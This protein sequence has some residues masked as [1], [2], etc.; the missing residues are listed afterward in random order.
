MGCNPWSW[1]KDLTLG[2]KPATDPA[3]PCY[4]RQVIGLTPH[5]RIRLLFVPHRI[6]FLLATV[7]LVALFGAARLDYQ[8]NP[9]DMYLR[10][11]PETDLLEHIYQTFGSDD[12]TVF[13]LF[14][15][16][17][18][19]FSPKPL[20]QLQATAE[21]LER[22]PGVESVRSLFD[23][24]RQS[25]PVPL[26]DL[27]D[28]NQSYLDAVESAAKRHPLAS[29]LLLSQQGDATTLTVRLAG[30]SL[31]IQEMTGVL[32]QIQKAVAP[33]KQSDLWQVH[34]TGPTVIR[35]ESMQRLWAEQ[36]KLAL[37]GGT[38]S[39]LIAC[40]LFRQW[41]AILVVLLGP[42]LGVLWTLGL[43][44]W[45]GQR[46]D[47]IKVIIPTLV[48]VIGFTDSLHLLMGL[49]RIQRAAGYRLSTFAAAR[50]VVGELGLACWMTS[51]TTAIGFGSL[52]L[53]STTSVQRFGFCC[54]L[55]AIVLYGAVMLSFFWLASQALGS[56]IVKARPFQRRMPQR[57]WLLGKVVRLLRY[58]KT[59]VVTSV[60]G[61]GAMLVVCTRLEPNIIWTEAV[62]RTSPTMQAIAST[63]KHF[64]GT[65]Y[66]AILVR[67]NETQTLTSPE[68]VRAMAAAH[69]LVKLQPEF[70]PPLS[71]ANVLASMD[72]VRG[73]YARRWQSLQRQPTGQQTASQFVC[74]DQREAVIYFLTADLGARRINEVVRAV[75]EQLTQVQQQT[76]VE[77]IL[78][79]TPV[80]AGRVFTSMI[81]ELAL[82]L[83]V[84]S[85]LVFALM[86]FVLRSLRLGVAS[87]LP[88]MFPLLVAG[89]AIY[90]TT[91]FLTLTNT[92]TFC[93]CLGI[94][95]DDTIHYLKAF[96]LCRRQGMPVPRSIVVSLHRVG[97]VLLVSSMILI[98]GMVAMLFS[99]LPPLQTFSALAILAIVAALIGD[100]LL[101]PAILLLLT[102]KTHRPGQGVQVAPPAQF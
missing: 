37:I 38:L 51:L 91:G 52:M 27:R 58:P 45:L 9:R 55:G 61:C 8:D 41:Q 99:D 4:H 10:A 69:Q 60:M 11:G 29:G 6:G 59:I 54:A 101:L 63:E 1:W 20:R 22:I 17:Q 64:G 100:L 72:Y 73:G 93:L 19:L 44:G 92:L 35:V 62:S 82:S 7:S 70:G 26:I 18:R 80:V 88:N 53:S 98:G 34:V 57:S 95:V 78:G 94:A 67:W 68:V 39:F 96:Q 77:L 48:F 49:G 50:Q 15:S 33:L 71:I 13:L 76:G 25:V 5:W 31:N 21:R 102:A 46:M 23:L 65:T 47:G 28:A 16:S 83:A 81:G 30:Q 79:G 32:L 43:M 14:Q 97:R 40:Y 3:S 42:V 90:F 89:T 2:G 85:I 74:E 56:S 36:V 12:N 24:R 87:I 66:A 84:A 86:T 75:Q